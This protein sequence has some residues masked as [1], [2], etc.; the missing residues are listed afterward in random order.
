MRLL[1]LSLLIVGSLL[2]CNSQKQTTE[3][4][5]IEQYIEH[6]LPYTGL[7]SFQVRDNQWIR[8]PENI[9]TVHE[10]LKKSFYQ[11]YLTEEILEETPF[12]YGDLYFNTPL[13]TKI[14][15]LLLTYAEHQEATK[16][17]REFW[18]RRKQE[19]NDSTVNLVL[20]EVQAMMNGQT[21]EI[22]EEYV[23][24]TL[25]KLI[26]IWGDFEN[27][28][29]EKANAHFA[30]FKAMKM[31]QSAYNLLYENSHYEALRIHRDSLVA[32]LVSEKVNWDTVDSRI[33]FIEDNTK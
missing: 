26:G 6:Q 5:N 10:T 1:L 27:M 9:L 32:T 12:I 25:E 15:S 29:V 23:N 13:K 30:F 7:C 8:N 18:E 11:K 16:Y 28:T 19:K 2:S 3:Q 20:G 22:R 21:L 14:D 33:V 31:H 24:A 17:Y 4:K